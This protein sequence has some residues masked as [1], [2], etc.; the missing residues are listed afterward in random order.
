MEDVRKLYKRRLMYQTV[1]SYI[2]SNQSQEKFCSENHISLC[3]LQYWY[4]KYNQEAQ[5]EEL[6]VPV[7]VEDCPIIKAPEEVK[8]KFPNGMIVEVLS[9][10]PADL[11]RSLLSQA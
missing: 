3:K 2:R 5:T 8:I 11:I 1:M 10:E 9:S 7:V 4:R 6:L